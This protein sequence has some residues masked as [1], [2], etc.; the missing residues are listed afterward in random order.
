MSSQLK[1]PACSVCSVCNVI[2]VV[3]YCIFPGQYSCK[4]MDDSLLRCYNKVHW[5]HECNHNS[6]GQI[7]QYTNSSIKCHHW[8]FMDLIFHMTPQTYQ[9]NQNTN[10]LF[11]IM[12]YKMSFAKW[13]PYHSG[14]KV[15]HVPC[16]IKCG[17]PC[18]TN[19]MPSHYPNK[20]WLVMNCNL[21]E[22]LLL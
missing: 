16:S 13:Q 7:L 10:I 3:A 11:K 2:N 17:S 19:L 12:C 18:F 14:P 8:F 20:L 22:K 4:F 15:W 5:F 1:I 6:P 21:Q 9:T